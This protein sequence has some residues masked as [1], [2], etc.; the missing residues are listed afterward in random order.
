MSKVLHTQGV[1]IT[2]RGVMVYNR[3]GTVGEQLFAGKKFANP[4]PGELENYGNVAMWGSNNLLPNEMAADIEATGVLSAGIDAKVR[5]ALGKGPMPAKIVGYTDD[6]YE[7]LEFVPDAE[8]MDWLEGTNA[9]KQS[10]DTLKDLFGLGNAFQQLM[11]TPDRSYMLGYKRQD[12]CKCR[13][14]VLNKATGNIDNVL[15]SGDWKLYANGQFGKDDKHYATVPL[16][17]RDFP[18][19]DLQS[20]K[21]GSTYMIALQYNLT[22][23]YYYAPSPW[24][25]AKRWVKIAQGI[26]EMKEAMFKNQMTIKYVVDIHPAFWKEYDKKFETASPDEQNKIQEEFVGKIEEYL[27]GGENAYKSLISTKVFDPATNS[28]VSAITI[29]PLDDKQKDGKLIIDSA[30]ANMEIL[31]PLMINS[32]LLGVDFPGNGAGGGAGSGSDIREAFLVQVMLQEMERRMNST[33][34]DIAKRVNGWSKRIENL[35]FRYPNQ[36]LTTLNTG[37]NTQSTA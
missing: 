18:L 14:E 25:S 16:L 33:V 29:T 21:S 24:Y 30:S 22:G 27:I 37:K 20:R 3:A 6:G 11:F 5:I 28:F 7:L 12:G 2:A 32:A 34:F 36:I 9:Y 8:I 13:F 35:V 31:L 1:S 17:N 23:R 19:F 10:Y 15:M 4:Q 26:P